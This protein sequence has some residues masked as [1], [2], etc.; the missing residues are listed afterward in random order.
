MLRQQRHG[1]WNSGSQEELKVG[2]HTVRLKRSLGEGGFA[3]IHLVEVR[4]FGFRVSA[5]AVSKQQTQ[6]LSCCQNFVG[7]GTRSLL[8]FSRCECSPLLRAQ[9]KKATADKPNARF[10]ASVRCLEHTALV[11]A[12]YL[13]LPLL[14]SSYPQGFDSCRA[15]G[16]ALSAGLLTHV[17]Y[18]LREQ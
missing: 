14:Y 8:L 9:Y 17:Y 10:R 11:A 18:N 4:R 2:R 6:R 16:P 12:I 15:A 5:A 7:G 13:E 1:S 3:F